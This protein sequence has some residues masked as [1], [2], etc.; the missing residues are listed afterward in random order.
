MNY[1]IVNKHKP[2]QDGRA[3]YKE[4]LSYFVGG[5]YAQIELQTA[6]SNLVNNKL[7]HTTLNGAEGYNSKFN[8]YI[9]T[10]EQAGDKLETNI[11]RCLYL[12]NIQDDLY[13]TIKDQ[14]GLDSMSLTDIQSLM[15]KKYNSTLA[16]R[17]E[18]SPRYNR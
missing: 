9:T 1:N 10:I 16:E 2:T 5:S 14:T 7:T 13:T 11:M 12:A 8:D 6:I 15:L 18:D 17:R 3:V 4:A